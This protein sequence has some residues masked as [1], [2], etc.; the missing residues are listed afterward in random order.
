[1]VMH[2]RIPESVDPTTV[3]VDGMVWNLRFLIFV[4]SRI[5]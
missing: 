3:Y 2:M 5:G 1:M 4:I